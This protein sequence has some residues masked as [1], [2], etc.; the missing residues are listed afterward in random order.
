MPAFVQ[1][2]S[3]RGAGWCVALRGV[4]VHLDAADGIATPG[5]PFPASVTVSNGGADAVGIGWP[6]MLL[7]NLEIEES[8]VQEPSVTVPPGRSTG[9]TWRVV[10]APGKAPKH[11]GI[12]DE[13][14]IVESSVPFEPAPADWN[15][16]VFRQVYHRVIT[17]SPSR[18]ATHA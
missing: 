4:E 15:G 12:V 10:S 13:A 14:P 6:R 9:L 3:D 11:P 8:P 5:A 2:A 18:C 1:S 17:K 16:A 7:T